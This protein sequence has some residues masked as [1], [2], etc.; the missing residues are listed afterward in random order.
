MSR[1]FFWTPDQRFAGQTV[2]VLA[3]G[4]SLSRDVAEAVRGRA[5]IVVNQT[6]RTAPWAPVWFFTD[7]ETLERNVADVEAWP[8]DVV[9]SSSAAH[10]AAPD[11]LKLI[12]RTESR[13][14]PPPGSGLVKKG[15]STGHTAIGLAAA[16]GAARIVLLGFD[17]R[18]VD[19]REH[20]HD[21]Y[22]GTPRNP[23]IYAE[24]F[25]PGFA[26]W[27]AAA[28]RAGFQILNATPGSAIDEF[29]RVGLEEML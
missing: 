20:G 3:S 27:D 2:F 13:D 28:R 23:A 16:M 6:F 29:Q 1:L 11:K 14:F 7:T 25:V 9:T 18:I 12:L 26:G 4:P 24:E 17:M 22:A 19:G 10:R 5:A 21:D 15:R 8:G